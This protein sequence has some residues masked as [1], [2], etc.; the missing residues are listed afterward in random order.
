V[1]F[2]EKL[3]GD[4]HPEPGLAHMNL[5]ICLRL[6]GRLD[7]AE[8]EYA[9]A[10]RILERT[11]GSEYPYM[12]TILMDL[13]T[14]RVARGRPAEGEALHRR[15]LALGERTLGPSHPELADVLVAL[16]DDAL[17]DKR[18]AE[19]VALAERGLTLQPPERT[20]P[21]TLA[22][23]RF[24]LARGL[25][26]SGGDRARA[27]ELAREA[28]DGYGDR[29]PRARADRARVEAWLGALENR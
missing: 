28:R 7:E 16:A 23:L 26:E 20:P 19:A 14:I 10:R 24:A 6:M 18:P 25:R 17:R 12:T 11:V 1:E 9:E 3:L 5:A 8:R 22:D 15:A 27:R 2:A 21:R 13:G 29:T 4:K